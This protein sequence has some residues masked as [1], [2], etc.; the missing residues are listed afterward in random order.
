MVSIYSLRPVYT[1][2]YTIIN[3]NVIAFFIQKRKVLRFCGPK[4]FFL[5]K[6]ATL[7]SPSLLERNR[8]HLAWHLPSP[9]VRTYYV[10]DP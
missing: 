1:F 4:T 8:S 3:D 10:D 9:F 2:L 5:R 6:Y 7:N